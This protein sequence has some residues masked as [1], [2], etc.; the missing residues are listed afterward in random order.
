MHIIA[1]KVCVGNHIILHNIK[2]EVVGIFT[3]PDDA[4][5]TFKFKGTF[6]DR[7]NVLPDDIVEVDN[8]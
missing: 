1:E 5:I 2:H 6:S 8:G 3:S 4:R 7:M